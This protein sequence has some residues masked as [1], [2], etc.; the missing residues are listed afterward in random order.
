M[1][2]QLYE[3]DVNAVPVEAVRLAAR[4]TGPNT[5]P[6][7]D[8]VRWSGGSGSA[9]ERG[10]GAGEGAEEALVMLEGRDRSDAPPIVRLVENG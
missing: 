6:D 2:W 4:M 7:L 1:S 10:G 5:G 8:G 9:V 3:G